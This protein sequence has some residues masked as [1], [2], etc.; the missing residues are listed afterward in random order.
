MPPIVTL[1]REHGGYLTLTL[2]TAVGILV[3]PLHLA[4]LAIGAALGLGFVAHA[5]LDRMAGGTP[6]RRWDVPV[7]AL[8]LAGACA[9]AV[10]ASRTG[11]A[12]GA[13][14]L[15][16][17]LVLPVGSYLV[18]RMRNH[19]AVWFELLAM[20]GL[21]ASSGFTAWVG[22]AALA[23]SVLAGAL[24]GAH[25][26]VS[27]P[28]VR[29]QLRAREEASGGTLLWAAAA[30]LGA[31]ALAFLLGRPAAA[32]AVVP[33]LVEVGV[34]AARGPRPARPFVIGLIE[35]AELLVAGTVVVA[36]A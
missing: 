6:P 19:R 22:G 1:P 26:A 18:R 20:G 13:L 3:A 28:L 27:V 35:T 15:A 14:A 33:R 9:L 10:M 31:A 11:G 24:L 23:R 12:P 17:V 36:W 34:R 25:A 8:C 29:T 4:A 5:P 2:A 16:G 7:T 21:G 30:L 32:L